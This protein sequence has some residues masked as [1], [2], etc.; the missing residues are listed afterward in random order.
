MFAA[1]LP[2]TPAVWQDLQALAPTTVGLIIT[3]LTLMFLALPKKQS[4]AIAEGDPCLPLRSGRSETSPSG[5][6]AEDSGKPNLHGTL[7]PSAGLVRAN[8]PEPYVF[9]N[10]FCEGRVLVLH[11]PTY[12]AAVDKSGKFP[13]GDHFKGRKRLWELRVQFRVKAPVEGP[14]L[15]GIELE[16]YVPL[17][18]SAKRL[19]GMTVAALK[20]VAGNDLYHSVG[21]DPSKGPGPHEK[22]V[23]MMPLWACDQMIVTPEGEDPPD[24]CDSSYSHYGLKR[25]DDRPAFVKEMEALKL[26][27]GITY[28]MSFWGISQ[29]LDCIKWEMQKII[30]FKPIDFNLFCGKPPVHLVLYTLQPSSAG[31]SRH[32]ESRKNYFFRY[33]LW[34]SMKGPSAARIRELIPNQ[35]GDDFDLQRRRPVLPNQKRDL[36]SNMFACCASERPQKAGA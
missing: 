20:Q 19:M 27:P 23:F 32:L 5:V 34:S 6:E 36:L 2:L 17:G 14:L 29:F 9:D 4:R 33:A 25:A 18:A 22:P 10:A 3:G 31:E 30:P 13:Y 15:V 12:D 28:S 21:D 24:L 26:T 16:K 1:W 8:T 7:I 35:G 11:R